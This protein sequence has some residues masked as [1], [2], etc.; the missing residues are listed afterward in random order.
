[1]RLFPV[2]CLPKA[3]PYESS[4]YCAISLGNGTYI[5]VYGV[6]EDTL[7]GRGYLL[8]RREDCKGEG[9]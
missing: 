7:V 8:N 1:M 2:Y 9:D 3:L 6:A 5:L 4:S